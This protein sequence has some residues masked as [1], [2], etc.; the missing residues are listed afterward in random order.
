M[1]CTRACYRIPTV[2]FA[3]DAHQGAL[4]TFE[5]YAVIPDGTRVDDFQIRVPLCVSDLEHFL[6][7]THQQNAPLRS[8]TRPLGKIRSD[9]GICGVGVVG[10]LRPLAN[11]LIVKEKL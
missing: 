10:R 8:A 7:T 4:G 6:H 3:D 11:L 5:A 2:G 1:M 9:S